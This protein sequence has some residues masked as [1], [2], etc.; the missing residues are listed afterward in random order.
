V[1]VSGAEEDFTSA[2]ARGQDDA[3]VYYFRGLA[4]YYQDNDSGVEKDFTTAIA[5]GRDDAEV[6]YYRGL[7]RY[8]QG[9]HSEAEED[10]TTAIARGQDDADVYHFR[11]FA[12]ARLERLELARYDCEQADER[13]SGDQF[14][15]GCWGDLHLALR[16]YDHAIAHYESALEAASGTGWH[17]EL[18]LALLLAV[19]LMMRKP[20]TPRGL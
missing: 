5:R 18:G 12:N 9:N 3:G 2:I 4:R 10:F 20:P 15:H 13:A 6:Y 17:F 8:A 16:E 11:A 7:A 1:E 19:G 14:T